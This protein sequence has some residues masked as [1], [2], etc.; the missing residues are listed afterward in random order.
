MKDKEIALPIDAGPHTNSNVEWWYYFAFLQGD[1][2]GRYA[3]M[4][5][6]FEVGETSL[7]KA[8]YMIHSLIDLTN[9]VHRHYSLADSSLKKQMALFYMPLYLLLNPGDTQMWRLQK[10]LLKGRL[11]KPH[12]GIPHA[13]VTSNPV[14]LSYGKNK[15]EFLGSSQADYAVNIKE[16]EFEA[17]LQ[18]SPEKPIA[19]IGGQGKP[20]DL[21][22]YSF[23]RNKVNGQIVTDRGAETVYGQGWFDHQWGRDYGLAKGKGWDWFGIQLDDGRELLLNQMTSDKKESGPKMANLIG[24]D[25]S[26]QFSRQVS[27]SKEKHWKSFETNA[28]YPISWSITIPEFRMELRVEAAFPKQEMI[29]LG[30]LKGIWEGAVKVT[31]REIMANGQ[32]KPLA[33]KGFMELVGYT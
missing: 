26:L 29:I 12:R 4:G 17:D 6:F 20:D 25:G 23:T 28:R 18:F 24:R 9:N 13:R 19:L 33:G 2:G 30:P 11:P 8:H 1:R 7:F 5:S 16:K 21:Y 32:R 14:K 15:L 3:V 31:G 10:Q 27:F 22:Y